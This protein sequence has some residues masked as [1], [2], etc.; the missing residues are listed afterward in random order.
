MMTLVVDANWLPDDPLEWPK[1]SLVCGVAA[2]E[3]AE[4]L[5]PELRVRL[6]WPNDL[7]VAEKKLGGIL[8]ESILASQRSQPPIWLIGIGFNTHIAWHEAPPGLRERAICLS[9]ASGKTVHCEN[10][11]VVLI[12]SLQRGLSQWKGGAADW[13]SQWDNR[14]LL[15]R[16][17]VE[18]RI[19]P[20]ISFRG[21][22]EGINSQG[23]LLVRSERE[24]RSIQ[25]G[26]II[27]YNNELE[28]E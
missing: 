4:Q 24:V 17:L 21:R 26:E 10:M 15:N 11:L 6:K 27:D 22:C 9:S 8:V 14:S 28:I 2:A 1:L 16:R 19:P 20:G 5:A 25:A 13:L 23:H 7:Y 3:A 18:V 12:E